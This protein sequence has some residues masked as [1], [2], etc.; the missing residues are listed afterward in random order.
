MKNVF[1]NTGLTLLTVAILA[2]CSGNP[3]S[4]SGQETVEK[5]S[6]KKELSVD[7][8]AKNMFTNTMV[9]FSRNNVFSF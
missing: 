2:A 1:R 7:E 3:S 5:V 8:K 6:Q 4:D 9:V